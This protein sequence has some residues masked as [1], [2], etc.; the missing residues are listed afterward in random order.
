MKVEFD[1]SFYRSLDRISTQ[2]IL[3]KIRKI[4]IEIEGAISLREIKNLKKL[5]GYS[6]YYRIKFGDYRIG[7]ELI[8]KDT[9]RLI[10]VSH[11]KDIYRTFP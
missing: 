3:N 6:N 1:N 10:V 2:Y 9:I 5:S 4:I 8:S 7:F 11:R